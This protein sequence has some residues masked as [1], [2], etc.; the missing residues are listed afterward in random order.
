LCVYG[1]VRP[2]D[3]MPKAKDL[4][5]RAISLR[6][7]TAEAHATLGAV[8]GF[9][10]WDWDQ[11]QK[12]LMRAL[13]LEPGTAASHYAYAEYYLLPLNRLDEAVSELRRA[14]DL[15][16][17]SAPVHALLGRA[18]TFRGD[19]D[20]AIKEL[21]V[22]LER[23][24]NFYWSH[25]ALGMAYAGKEQFGAARAALEKAYSLDPANPFNVGGLAYL[26]AITGNREAALKALSQASARGYVSPFWV[27]FVHTGLGDK[28]AAIRAL[29]TGLEERDPLLAYVG[30][31]PELKSLRSD[32]RLQDLLRQMN[33][34]VPAPGIRSRLDPELP[35]GKKGAILL[36]SSL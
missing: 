19:Y 36:R 34:V 15:D 9:Y 8:Y 26:D 27:A 32:P 29:Q 4:A 5:L 24:P 7:A 6:E 22:T 12:E 23:D 20:A 14:L 11:A 10:E 25:W 21:Q 2:K 3:V 28:D 31:V 17:M 18:L 13:E 30:V 1:G 33:L 35:L 16:P